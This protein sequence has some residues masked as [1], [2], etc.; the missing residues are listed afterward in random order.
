MGPSLLILC[1]TVTRVTDGIFLIEA[2]RLLK[3]GGYFVWTS[4]ITNA[5]TFLRNK[6]NK[7]RWDIVHDFAEN[8]CWEMLSQQDETVVWKKTSKRNCYSSR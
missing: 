5:Q 8:L 2:D 6:V 4:P 3:P 7:K 1:K